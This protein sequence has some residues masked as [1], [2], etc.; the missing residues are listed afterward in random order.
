MG[1]Q[2]RGRRGRVWGW[3]LQPTFCYFPIESMHVYRLVVRAVSGCRQE[4]FRSSLKRCF[5]DCVVSYSALVAP[6]LYAL[7]ILH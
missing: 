3:A 7:Y 6:R 1:S 2:E 5:D 4:H